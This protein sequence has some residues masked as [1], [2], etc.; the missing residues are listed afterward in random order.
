MFVII[1]L[2][3]LS[4]DILC[5]IH[6]NYWL[7]FH[8][9][10]YHCQK[11][12]MCQDPCWAGITFLWYLLDLLFIK[13]YKRFSFHFFFPSNVFSNQGYEYIYI[14]KPFFIMLVFKIL[15]IAS[16][17]KPSITYYF[18]IFSKFFLKKKSQ[19]LLLMKKI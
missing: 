10:H 3:P 11:L 12:G 13:Q 8:T 19:L 14:L 1:M 4:L 2:T 15:R 6:T 9:L 16:S 18:V 7:T 5:L 17:H